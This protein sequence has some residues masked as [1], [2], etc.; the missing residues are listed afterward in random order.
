M[1]DA[2]YDMVIAKKVEKCSIAVRLD[3]PLGKTRTAARMRLMTPLRA[4]VPRNPEERLNTTA[5]LMYGPGMAP[6]APT[7]A[8]PPYPPGRRKCNVC[9]YAI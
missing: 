3:C 9:M 5:T 4:A 2:R 1:N 6:Q 8:C 7:H